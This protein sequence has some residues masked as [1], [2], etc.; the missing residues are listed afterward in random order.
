MKQIPFR[1][2]WDV[3]DAWKA[4]PPCYNSDNP[5][6]HAQ[7]PYFYECNPE[8]LEEEDEIW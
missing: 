8:D 4:N 6:C 7:C 2:S 3:A 5:Y 1:V